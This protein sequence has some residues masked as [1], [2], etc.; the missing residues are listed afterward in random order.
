MEQMSMYQHRP[1]AEIIGREEADC[2]ENEVM[3]MIADGGSYEDVED[4]MLGYGL[5]MDYLEDL[6]F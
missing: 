1:V 4:I 6:L 3:D 5:K 2:L